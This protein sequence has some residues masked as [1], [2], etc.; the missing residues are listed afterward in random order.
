[1]SSTMRMVGPVTDTPDWE[2]DPHP[3]P[4]ELEHPHLHA[5]PPDHIVNPD[6][7]DEDQHPT[8]AWVVGEMLDEGSL[9]ALRSILEGQG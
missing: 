2:V 8:G 4:R 6:D 9:A 3:V 1:M 5:D 7:I